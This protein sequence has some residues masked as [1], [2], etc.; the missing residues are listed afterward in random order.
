MTM[1]DEAQRPGRKTKRLW[2]A[3]AT[4]VV[5]LVVLIVPP[6]VSIGRY[7]SRI[8]ACIRLPG[9]ACASLLG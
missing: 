5:I 8:T 9:P 6:L 1:T 3:L 7:K 4:V 2:L